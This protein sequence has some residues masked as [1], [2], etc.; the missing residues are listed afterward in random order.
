MKGRA[1]G[2]VRALAL[3]GWLLFAATVPR[4]QAG[5]VA[6]D[7][8]LGDG[9][10][11]SRKAWAAAAA[12][13]RGINLAVY[14]APREG[15]WGLRMDDRWV[16]TLAKAGFRSVRL[17]VR[18][19]NHAA[20]GAEATL[21]EAFARRIDRLTDALL[22]RGLRVVVNMSFYSQLDGR[23]LEEGEMAVS[24]EAVRPRFVNLW[25][26]LA[27]R[28]ADRSDRLLF[29][30]YNVP[31]G[32]ARAW[33]DL[34]ASALA[35][36]RQSSPERMVIISPLHNDPAALERL[37]LPPDGHL[38]TSIHNREPHQFTYQGSPWI[39]GSEK[40]LGTPCC[41]AQQR[42]ALALNLDLAQAWSG[43][44]RYPVWLGSFGTASTA[45][46][47]ARANYLRAMR[48]AAEARGIS[49]AHADFA[50]NF[51]VRDPPLDSGIYDVVRR[52]WHTPLLD[53][54][55]GP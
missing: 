25:R 17:S 43:R 21:D 11:A 18:W 48:D 2:W 39:P 28:Y 40:W 22:A 4:A 5:P 31:K 10:G 54:L 33:N 7:L 12:L 38:I 37:S 27:K 8:P 3:A 32:E 41:D 29:E 23:P 51:N 46:M 47:P 15:D 26:Q 49:W 53:A 36:I 52:K 6:A 35:A 14:A 42:Q 50:A 45:P 20:A 1:A 16:D 19:S 13:S 44:T 30:L 55:L 34:A 24:P 9:P